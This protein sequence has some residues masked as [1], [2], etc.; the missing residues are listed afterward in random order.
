MR[1]L[2]IRGAGDL[3]GTRQHGHIAAVGFNLYTRLLAEAVRRLRSHGELPLAAASPAFE[4]ELSIPVNVDLPLGASIPADYVADKAMRLRLYRRM[5]DVRSLDEVD[6]LEEEFGDRFG[7]PPEA[8]QSL[9]LQL[10]IKL[11]A[12]NAGLSSVSTENGQIVLRF[13]DG[14]VPP[15]LPSLDA[16]VRPGKTALWIQYGNLSDWRAFLLEIL[17]QLMPS[18]SEV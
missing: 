10:K 9:L 14:E 13:T 8:V 2:E 7:S 3:L 4:K 12:E 11:L 15:D 16:R 6:A 1:D 17:E 18:G 5:A